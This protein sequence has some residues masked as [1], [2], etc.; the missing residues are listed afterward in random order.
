MERRKKARRRTRISVYVSCPGQKMKR[1]RASNLSASGAFIETEFLGVT[2]GTPVDLVF[3][4]DHGAV[5]RMYRMPATVARVSRN[6]AGVMLN[7]GS[8]RRRLSQPQAF[9]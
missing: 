4:L 2:R 9:S 3:V 1:C 6:G 8:A 5:V 7:S